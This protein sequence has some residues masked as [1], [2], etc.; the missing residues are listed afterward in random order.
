[1]NEGSETS[2]VD[3]GSIGELSAAKHPTAQDAGAATWPHGRQPGHGDRQREQLNWVPQSL[4]RNR[5]AASVAQ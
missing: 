3:A 1:M 2:A 5:W 4:R